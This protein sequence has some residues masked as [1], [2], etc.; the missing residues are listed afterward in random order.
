MTAIIPFP[1]IPISGATT[2]DADAT[3]GI[4]KQLFRELKAIINDSVLDTETMTLGAVANFRE[5]SE[6]GVR[7]N[8]IS[9]RLREGRDELFKVLD[10]LCGDIV[11]RIQNADDIQQLWGEHTWE[12]LER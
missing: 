4:T 10:D 5:N 3:I 1:K 6:A 12:G 8:D 9:W 11:G 2:E 7:T